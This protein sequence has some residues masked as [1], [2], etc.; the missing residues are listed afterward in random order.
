MISWVDNDC[1]AWSAHYRWQMLGDDG[2]P[3]RSILGRLIDEGPGAGHAPFGTR[4]LVKDPPDEYRFINLALQHMALTREMEKP[5]YAIHLHYLIR[6][7][8]KTKA[9]LMEVSVKQYWNLLHAGHA[10]IAACAPV[11]VPRGALC[12]QKLACA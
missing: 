8:A 9:P 11:D 10:F 4:V 1:R 7:R 2:W 5:R 12:T 6:G 3:E